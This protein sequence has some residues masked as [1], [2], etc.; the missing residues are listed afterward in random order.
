MQ[1]A[2]TES[3]RDPDG[4]IT[5]LY[6]GRGAFISGAHPGGGG[7]KRSGDSGTKPGGETILDGFNAVIRAIWNLHKPLI[8]AVHK[9]ASGFAFSVSLARDVRLV[10]STALS[11]VFSVYRALT[12]DGGASY[13]SPRFA[14][15][16]GFE[17]ALGM[18]AMG[19]EQGKQAFLALAKIVESL[20][21]ALRRS[22]DEVITHEAAEQ[23]KIVRTAHFREGFSAFLAK[24]ESNCTG[25]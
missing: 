12:V 8:S 13:F 24:R 14:D 23:A 7:C 3:A 16:K 1:D 2:L 9:I 22:V 11:P 17:L 18:E 21:D 5:V 15:L 4:R 6:C 25:Q 20:H 10:S 19:A